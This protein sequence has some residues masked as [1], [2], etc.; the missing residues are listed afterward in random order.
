MSGAAVR[1]ERLCKQQ[2][3]NCA[4]RMSTARLNEP[5]KSSME[6]GYL[7]RADGGT[8]WTQ[9][10]L[11]YHKPAYGR[12]QSANVWL[13]TYI[14][15]YLHRAELC[16][17]RA[18]TCVPNFSFPGIVGDVITCILMVSYLDMQPTVDS[19]TKLLRVHMSCIQSKSSRWWLA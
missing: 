18:H 2:V 3:G 12:L 14:L 15:S 17:L 5:S 11:M 1:S 16:P 7:R 6:S 8:V 13:A 4:R 19:T 9:A 10:R